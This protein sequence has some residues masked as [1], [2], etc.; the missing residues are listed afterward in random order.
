[1][2]QTEAQ[3]E[4][5]RLN[6]A[7]LA[8]VSAQPRLA[9]QAAATGI[10]MSVAA[11]RRAAGDSHRPVTPEL[12]LRRGQVTAG[13][14][15]QVLFRAL[16]EQ[17]GLNNRRYEHESQ[18]ELVCECK[19]QGCLERLRVPRDDYEAVR[20]F[21]TRFLMKPGHCSDGERVAE[22]RD[23]YVVVEQNRAGR[24]NSDPSRPTPTPQPPSRSLITAVMTPG[25]PRYRLG[26]KLT[27][28]RDV[29]SV[30]PAAGSSA[31][32]L[33]KEHD[34]A[35]EEATRD[36]VCCLH[37]VLGRDSPCLE[38]CA[39]WK[40]GV[41]DQ[42]GRCDVWPLVAR[43]EFDDR[44]D[45]AGWLLRIRTLLETAATSEQ[46]GE[47][48]RHLAQARDRIARTA[49][50]TRTGEAWSGAET[51]VPREIEQEPSLV[52]PSSRCGRLTVEGVA[53][54]VS[55]SIEITAGQVRELLSLFALAQLSLAT[56]PGWSDGPEL[57]ERNL[58]YL[59]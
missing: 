27:R 34:I 13:I 53:E 26:P 19:H 40:Q 56:M 11:S 9:A 47:A 29:N 36:A 45:N 20:R 25:S 39:F 32:E 1:M 24:R 4:R 55:G 17:I 7:R 51:P 38:A 28:P 30:R 18:L 2:K 12:R 43:L 44:P 5:P 54:V 49:Q 50:V 46:Q 31:V 52:S 42:Q 3:P 8:E 21:P 15:N 35:A 14:P 10:E 57:F 58:P 23:G 41:G 6:S 22:E 48:Q 33:R 59:V 37:A 16:N